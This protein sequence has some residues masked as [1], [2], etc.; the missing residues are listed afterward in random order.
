[1]RAAG[2]RVAR[3]TVMLG[4]AALALTLACGTAAQPTKPGPAAPGPAVNMTG[5]WLG[6][7]VCGQGPTGLMLDITQEGQGLA[8]VFSFGPTP[9]NPGVPRGAFRM[10]GRVAADGSLRLHPAGWIRQPEGYEPVSL[11]G[12]VAGEVMHGR[13]EHPTC[14]DFMLTR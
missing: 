9:G 4:G 12:W 7:Y 8:A 13:I 1:M 5:R 3:R 2:R 14:D 6:G 11:S 10:T